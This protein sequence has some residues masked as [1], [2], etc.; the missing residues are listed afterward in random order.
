MASK[1]HGMGLWILQREQLDIQAPLPSVWAAS[2]TMDFTG[3]ANGCSYSPPD[4]RT[5]G[6]SRRF[7][8]QRRKRQGQ[9]GTGSIYRCCASSTAG[10]SSHTGRASSRAFGR[11]EGME[12]AEAVA[13]AVQGVDARHC[14]ALRC[15]GGW[16]SSAASFRHQARAS[17]IAAIVRAHQ[18]C[19]RRLDE[20]QKEACLC[21]DCLPGGLHRRAESRGGGCW[22]GSRPASSVRATGPR[23]RGSS[24]RCRRRLR[25]RHGQPFCR[26][27]GHLCGSRSA[28]AAPS[29]D[30]GR[31]WALFVLGHL[32]WLSR[33]L[34]RGQ[35]HRR[36][37]STWRTMHGAT[38]SRST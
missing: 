12:A 24:V 19:H 3:E 4:L 7:E 22:T 8:M 11:L 27:R 30:F 25:R 15:T 23:G 9:A 5:S 17:G 6:L 26:P 28:L 35:P 38:K 13:F 18:V 29:G 33:R 20:E 34:R 36:R 37:P 31:L 1:N 16:L 14:L 10:S 32:L 2:G 21:L